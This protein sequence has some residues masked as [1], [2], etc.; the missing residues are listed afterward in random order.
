MLDEN[1]FIQYGFPRD[2]EDIKG[3]TIHETGNEK[4]N[5]QELFDFLNNEN[6]TSQCYHYIC[7]DTKT[8]Q[9][10]PNDWGVYHTGKGM[11]Y[12]NRYTIAI[13]ICSNL[14]NEKYK[15]AQD[16]AVQLIKEL[17]QEYNLTSD[18]IFLHF[19]F[20]ERTY[21][22]KTIL[23]QYGSAKRFAYEEIE[24]GE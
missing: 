21:C 20:N 23:R 10:M 11:D 13:S 24:S 1:K 3:I 14:N 16:R 18:D 17:M 7:D 19:D 6:K 15:L 5:A 12:G 8:I 2:V 4:M 9:L 22:P